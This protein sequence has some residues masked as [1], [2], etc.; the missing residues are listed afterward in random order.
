MHIFIIEFQSMYDT[1]RPQS[2][3]FSTMLSFSVLFRGWDYWRRSKSC[4]PFLID[5]G[6]RRLP[7]TQRL[8][9]GS[10]SLPVESTVTIQVCHWRPSCPDNWWMW[11]LGDPRCKTRLHS[12]ERCVG[13]MPC[14]HCTPST[15]SPPVY[16]K[17]Q[18]TRGWSQGAV[19]YGQCSRSN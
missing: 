18:G 4:Q 13:D 11:V 3:L 14:W 6:G 19:L 8:P 1:F 5:S 17:Q 16:Y 2:H 9:G 12:L 15:C 10:Q 7:A